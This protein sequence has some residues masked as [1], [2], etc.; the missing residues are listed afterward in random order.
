[1]RRFRRTLKK[2]LLATASLCLALGAWAAIGRV[3]D[4]SYHAERLIDNYVFV[5]SKIMS[6]SAI[7]SFL[8]GKNSYLRNH[9]FKE[10][11]NNDYM[12][13]HYG[14]CGQTV[15]ASYI[16]YDA[17]H[18][19]GLSPRVIMA[20][21]QK[22]ESLITDPN[23]D[24][25]QVNFAMGYGCPDS[26]GCG[27]VKGFFN[28]VDNGTWQL[29]SNY[30]RASGDDTFSGT[31]SG[32]APFPC[33]GKTNFYSTG[34][35]PGRSVK[36]YSAPGYPDKTI[37]IAN[38]AT[39]SL[40]CYT[41][42]VGPFSETGYSG[43]F[44]FV[45]SYESWWGS[46]FLN[47]IHMK[48]V[49]SNSTESGGTAVVEYYFSVKPTNTVTIPLRLTDSSEASFSNSS[50]VTSTN[51]TI[52]PGDWNIPSHNQTKIYGVN[53]GIA[54][55]DIG[56]S[57]IAGT[58]TSSD[59]AFGGLTSRDTPNARLIN[60]D[61]EPDV[62]LGGHW[63]K[64]AAD[65]ICLK[66]GNEFLLNY[67][68]DGTKDV[69]FHYGVYTDRALV[70]DWDGNGK[71]DIAVIRSSGGHWVW[72]FN[73]GYNS[74]NESKISFGDSATD[75]PIAGDWNGDGKWDI[76]VA[77]PD[78]GRWQFFL[79][80]LKSGNDTRSDYR[81]IFGVTTDAIITGDWNKNHKTDIGLKR[82]DKYFLN[83]NHDATSNVTFHFGDAADLPVTG[84]WNKDGRTDIGL[85]RGDKYFLNYGFDGRS[86]V[87]FHYGR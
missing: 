44:N 43:S 18:A 26:G 69:D 57:V 77:R 40:Y 15:L 3:A 55:G 17:G 66:R 49:D 5:N 35:Y 39:A 7:Q 8:N 28:Q 47:P 73:T 81:F 33:P 21:I 16:I 78:G 14:H 54:D 10:N 2:P 79:N 50:S 85:K 42:H 19:Y 62:A 48:V 84:D 64:G 56:Y 65:T 53:D 71:S 25:S 74:Q 61:N 32:P 41:P 68:N 72:Y 60:N 51:L 6:R 87:T 80:V 38:A 75:V 67:Q 63:K 9:S 29:R 11:C 37:T 45:T 12:T 23:P 86:E 36:F 30:A 70:G 34:L 52:D 24:S 76:G 46:T 82:G 4:A 27:S 20:T 13:A 83:F 58:P 59:A 22:E 31:D 1:M